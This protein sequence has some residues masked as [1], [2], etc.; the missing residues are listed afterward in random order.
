MRRGTLAAGL[1]VVGAAAAILAIERVRP[2]RPRRD[3]EPARTV[4]NLALGA[5][6]M[7]VVRNLQQPVVEPLAHAVSRNRWGLAQRLPAHA[8]ARDAIAFL[9]LDYTIYLWH[10]M[11]HR[12]GFLWRFHLVHHIDLDLDASTALRFHAAEMA[13]SVPYRAA[14]VALLGVSP[15]A[16]GIWQNFFFAAILFH[17]SNLRLPLRLERALARAVM[18]PRL[19]G[20]HHSLVHEE[21]DS[22]WS[23]G[24]SVW[25]WL[26]GTLRADVPQG[27]VEVGVP[28]YHSR[29]H[30]KIEPSLRLP[31]VKQRP[32]WRTPDGRRVVRDPSLLRHRLL[33]EDTP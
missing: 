2:L 24:L 32:S 13:M 28:G 27:A 21:T 23:S 22:N 18:T 8:W 5:I 3:R 7:A 9:L 20:I 16:L 14:Q 25:D 12:I 30:V 1:L 26:H 17:H 11:T 4:R 10:V 15:R 29:E 19:H 33:P 6:S 31:F